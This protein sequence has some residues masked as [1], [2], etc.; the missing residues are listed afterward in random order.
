MTRQ[1][2]NA[3]HYPLKT[4]VCKAL[5][6][7]NLPLSMVVI[8]HP[9]E[10]KHAKNT[11]KLAKL[12]SPSIE[13]VSSSNSTLLDELLNNSIEDTVLVYP[14][15]NS[16]PIENI[17]LDVTAQTHRSIKRLI[18]IDS[19]WKQA[20]GI[21]KE[22]PRLHRYRSFHFNDIPKKQYQIRRSKKGSQLST[23]EAIAYCLNALF[24]INTEPYFKALHAM[25][26]HWPK[27]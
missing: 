16:T 3:C 13:I 15:P 10:A 6:V 17:R 4:C 24:D 20:Y 26:S 8:Q 14:N 7:V 1:Y 27:L 12:V 18:L 2:C 9:N 22:N 21:W 11:V 25:Q 19:T 5:V 23:I